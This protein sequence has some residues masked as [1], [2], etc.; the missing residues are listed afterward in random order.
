MHGIQTTVLLTA[1]ALAVSACSDDDHHDPLAPT[2]A[3]VESPVSAIATPALP[4]RGTVEATE[5]HFISDQGI[6]YGNVSGTGVATQL[7]RFTLDDQEIGNPATLAG[8]VTIVMRAANGDMLTATGPAQAMPNQ[9][10]TTLTNV[11]TVTI[12]GGTG[13]FAGAT[14][15][16]V[17]ERVID[18]TAGSP[19]PSR[20]S[21]SGT[22]VLAH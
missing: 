6:F 8:N 20:G 17:L 19:Y 5:T 1:A 3:F 12:T 2:V 10:F 16:F 22:I 11:E 7:G 14:G 18:L 9:S 4:F 13:R 21:L 15:S